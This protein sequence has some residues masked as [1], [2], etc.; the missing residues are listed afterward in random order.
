MEFDRNAFS[1]NESGQP[2]PTS[3]DAAK[4]MNDL[5]LVDLHKPLRISWREMESATWEK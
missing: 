1:K 5:A 4:T 3:P 2:H